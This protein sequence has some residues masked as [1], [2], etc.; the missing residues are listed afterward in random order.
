MA[1]QFKQHKIYGK[2]LLEIPSFMLIQLA[3]EK[4]L[5]NRGIENI[6]NPESLDYDY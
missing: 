5:Q 2:P 4:G 6:M 1:T 3:L